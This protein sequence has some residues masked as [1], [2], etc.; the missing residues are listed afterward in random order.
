MSDEDERRAMLFDDDLWT[1]EGELV[2]PVA[3]WSEP[4]G[5]AVR[6]WTLPDGRAFELRVAVD[7]ARSYWRIDAPDAPPVWLGGVT[8][9][10]TEQN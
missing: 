9:T 8:P 2:V 7:G 3:E 6:R 4:D 1:N 10:K 5:M